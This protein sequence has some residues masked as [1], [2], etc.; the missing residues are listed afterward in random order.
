MLSDTTRSLTPAG[1][2]NFP[3]EELDRHMGAIKQLCGADGD[4]ATPPDHIVVV[5]RRGN[6]SQVS[7]RATRILSRNVHACLTLSLR[8]QP[9][10]CQRAAVKR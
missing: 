6:D 7:Y 9:Q 2:V 5:C 10:W 1:S 3:F 4:A 8:L